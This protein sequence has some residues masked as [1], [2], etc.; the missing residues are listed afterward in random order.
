MSTLRAVCKTTDTRSETPLKILDCRVNTQWNSLPTY[1]VTTPAGNGSI[2]GICSVHGK[3]NA[4]GPSSNPNPT[5]AS[6]SAAPPAAAAIFPWASTQPATHSPLAGTPEIRAADLPAAH[7]EGEDTLLERNI[8]F[9][10]LVSGQV[11]E[12]GEAPPTYGEALNS[13]ARGTSRA[14]S[15]SQSRVRVPYTEPPS[16]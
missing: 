8:V 11:S 9:D 10:R 2:P 13:A 14:G 3:V 4:I 16:R 12:M 6:V 1:A 15:R 5:H 7:R